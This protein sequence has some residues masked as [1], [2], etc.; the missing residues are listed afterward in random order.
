MVGSGASAEKAVT[1]LLDTAGLWLTT[2]SR[3]TERQLVFAA[4]DALVACVDTPCLRELAAVS[5]R[6][7]MPPTFSV[8]VQD[9]FLELGTELP[10]RG[11]GEAES[12]ALAAMCR[13]LLGGSLATRELTGWAHRVITHG[14]VAE[15]VGL[16]NLADDYDRH[17]HARGDEPAPELDAE[18]QTE[19]S[20]IVGLPP[21]K[22]HPTGQT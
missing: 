8:T 16:V 10:A 2:P 20:R 21:R 17:D 11:S 5:V 1:A 13:R 6:S 4:A 3:E 9:A 15:A 7:P 18:A 14:G 22:A 12:L 19:A